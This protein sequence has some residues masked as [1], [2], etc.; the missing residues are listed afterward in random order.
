MKKLSVL[1]VDDERET[2]DTIAEVVQQLDL[3][4][5][6]AADGVE[7][8]QKLGAQKIDLILTDLLMPRMDGLELLARLKEVN[9]QIPV[10]VISG[11]GDA[12]KTTAAL[13]SGAFNFLAKPYSTGD[14]ENVVRKG[15]RLRELSL[16]TYTLSQHLKSVAEMELPTYP[17]LL[18]S[19]TLFAVKECQ[20]RGIEDDKL[21]HRISICVDELLTNAFLHGNKRNRKK[22]IHVRLSFDGEKV[23]FTVRDEG[24]GF[25]TKA[26]RKKFKEG[27]IPKKRGLFIVNYLMDEL[28]FGKKGTEAS[29]TKRFDMKDS[30][31]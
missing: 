9:P 18:P 13:T 10:A 2:R 6:T 15:L 14:I 8:L 26:L 21:L 11:Y 28:S 19:V 20:W 30:T 27:G 5:I 7:A 31:R 24:E 25:D 12:T 17:H 16:G 22:K 4:A 3:Q 1:I 29:F 23:T